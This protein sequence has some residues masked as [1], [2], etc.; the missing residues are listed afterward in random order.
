MKVCSKCKQTKS[1][2]E[3]SYDR[4]TKD[5]YQ[6]KCKMCSKRIRKEWGAKRK[7][8]L[9][10]YNARATKKIKNIVVQA[11]GGKCACCGES[12][13]SFLSVDHMNGDG[14]KH[15]TSLGYKSGG[16]IFHYWLRRNNFPEGFQILCRNCNWAKYAFGKCPHQT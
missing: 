16:R 13:L 3:F 15:R 2:S 10:E 1:L 8:Q 4:R 7:A 14:R 5:G 11:Y 9:K 12:E 6:H